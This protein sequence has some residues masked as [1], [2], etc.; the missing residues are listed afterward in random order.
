MRSLSC[1]FL[2]AASASAAP[3]TLR[4][5][6]FH[7][8]TRNEEH[9]SLDEVVLEPLPFHGNPAKPVDET[10]LGKYL[11]EVRDRESNR[12]LYS[13]GYSSIYGEWETTDEARALARSFHESV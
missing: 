1:L 7:T 11:F 12:L 3:R 4:V 6:Y 10:N 13:R 2:V 8:G 5:D 9:W